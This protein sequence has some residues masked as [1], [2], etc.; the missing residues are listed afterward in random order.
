MV[1]L[2][3][4]LL[5]IPIASPAQNVWGADTMQPPKD[6]ENI[7]VKKLAADSLMSSSVIWIKTELKPHKHATHSEQVNILDGTAS[8][9][10]GD[11]WI[12][13]KKGDII[14]IPKGTVH[15]VKVTSKTVFKVVSVQSPFA[16]GTD[17]IWVND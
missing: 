8:M 15:A 5:L 11:K 10:L 12:D 7:Y 1:R 3:I 17:R 13:V 6:F 4:L 2:L 9:R 14:F 16:D